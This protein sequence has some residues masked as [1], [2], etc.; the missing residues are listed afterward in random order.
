[1]LHD[2]LASGLELYVRH[3]VPVVITSLGAREDINAAIHSYGGLVLHDVIDNDIAHSRINMSTN[4]HQMKI[5]RA[6]CQTAAFG[7]WLPCHKR[8]RSGAK[9][10]LANNWLLVFCSGNYCQAQ[11]S[12]DPTSSNLATAS[13]LH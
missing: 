10:P 13:C 12:Y 7:P 11:E 8:R 2:R 6:S 3:R 1:M 5:W 9:L 4:W